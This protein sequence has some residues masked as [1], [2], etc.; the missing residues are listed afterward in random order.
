M[1]SR[2]KTFVLRFTVRGEIPEELIEREDLDE[3]AWLDEWEVGV[4][5]ALIRAVFGQIR[6]V[7]GWAAHVRNRGLSPLDEI[8]VVATRRFGE[9][10][11]GEPQ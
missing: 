5:P 11:A 2:E 3:D 9:D 1:E 7:P 10:E 6:A 8:E 4:K